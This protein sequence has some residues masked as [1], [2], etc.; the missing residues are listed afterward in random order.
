VTV[1]EGPRRKRGRPPHEVSARKKR[2]AP[3][4]GP[5]VPDEAW[6]DIET[7]IYIKNGSDP[8]EARTVVILKWMWYGNFKPL[9]AEI[10]AGHSLDT[11]VLYTLA[12]MLEGSEQ[13]PVR[14]QPVSH[15]RGRSRT[16][17]PENIIRDSI[18]AQAYEDADADGKSDEVFDYIAKAIGKSDRTVRQAVTAHRK[19]SAK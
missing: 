18:A 10:N 5:D 1:T 11:V 8:D 19:K 13:F 12:R 3:F 14:L 16:Q 17:R 4:K 15:R 2:N 6:W 7:E 9:I